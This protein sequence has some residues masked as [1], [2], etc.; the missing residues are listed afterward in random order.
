MP[1][2]PNGADDDNIPRQASAEWR[3]LSNPPDWK[4][5]WSRARVSASSRP[6]GFAR[7]LADLP[8]FARTR[9]AAKDPGCRRC[10]APKEGSPRRQPWGPRPLTFR[11]PQGRQNSRPNLAPKP[12]VA[13]SGAGSALRT[14]TQRSRAGLPSVGAP[15]LL[16]LTATW[17]TGGS[18]PPWHRRRGRNRHRY[19]VP[20]CFDPDSDPDTEGRLDGVPHLASGNSPLPAAFKLEP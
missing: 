3:P 16:R 6:R 12:S 14:R 20:S 19:R 7:N 2:R 18:A 11:A 9:E 4:T 10:G 8:T 1:P 5:Q 15:H 13:P 17:T